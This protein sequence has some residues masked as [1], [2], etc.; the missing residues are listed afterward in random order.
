MLNFYNK[1]L[2]KF[3]KIHLLNLVYLNRLNSITEILQIYKY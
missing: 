1:I 2:K 3:T